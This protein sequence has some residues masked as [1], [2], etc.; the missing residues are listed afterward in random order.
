M[1]LQSSVAS[2]NKYGLAVNSAVAQVSSSV[3]TANGQGINNSGGT[4]F[5][6]QDNA[7]SGNG[8]NV[9]GPLTPMTGV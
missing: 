9:V 6:R 5:T 8:S 3:F 7:V 2:G 1:T 4:V